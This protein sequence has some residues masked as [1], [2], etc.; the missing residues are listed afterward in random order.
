MDKELKL[1][2]DVLEKVEMEIR[3]LKNDIDDLKD[4]VNY[5]K[6]R[7]SVGAGFTLDSEKEITPETII[8][9]VADFF[10]VEYQD[11][12]SHKRNAHLIFVRRISIYLVKEMTNEPFKS[13]GHYFGNRDHATVEH[14]YREI[15]NMIEN[16]EKL[17][18]TVELLKGRISSQK[19]V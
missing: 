15:R 2:L 13:I 6:C 7:Q 18:N 3:D 9:I 16:D 1:I 17:K 10:Q 14:G 4:E 19:R 11:I 5:I 8:K 12:L